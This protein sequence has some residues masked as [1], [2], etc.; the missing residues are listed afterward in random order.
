MSTVAKLLGRKRVLLEQ[1]ESGPGPDEREEIER[2]LAQ[3][4]TALC[5]L[6]P[7]ETAPPGEE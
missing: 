2:L 4:D 1:L 7:E 3:I 6:G 5:L